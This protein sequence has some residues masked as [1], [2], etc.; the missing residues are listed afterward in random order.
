MSFLS[1]F[2]HDVEKG[3][4]KT[5][6]HQL[7][8][9][10][11][12]RARHP[13]HVVPPQIHKHNMLRALLRVCQQLRLQGLVRR[14]ICAPRSRPGERTVG[15]FAVGSDATQDLRR[16]RD[17]DRSAALQINHVR[18]RVDDAKRPV[19]LERVRESPPLK[20]LR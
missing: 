16:A 11:R 2:L 5:P 19:D 15:H 12:A 10:D 4:T 18:A 1:S 9:L 6:H 20:A 8:D 13:P 7:L 14:G 3:K 17:Q